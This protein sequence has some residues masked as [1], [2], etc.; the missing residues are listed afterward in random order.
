MTGVGAV[1]APAVVVRTVEAAEPE[2]VD[3]RRS[4]LRWGIGSY[5]VITAGIVL[6]GIIR[7]HGHL[8]YVIDDPAIHLSVAKNLVD[9]G[10]WG[11][12][13]GQFQSASSSPLW[14]IL[15]GAWLKIMPG[16]DALAPL[17]LN[18]AAAIGAIAVVAGNQRVLLPRWRRPLDALAVVVLVNVILFLPGLAMTGMEHSLHIALVLG[19][20]VLFHR[21]LTGQA[22]VGPSWLP[23]LL[24]VLATLTRFETAF[25]AAG[26]ALAL[27]VAPLARRGLDVAPG[28]D[29][30]VTRAR[31]PVLV[32]LASVVPLIAFGAFN[33]VMGQG[34]LPNSV[35]AK[36][37]TT[38]GV[39][40]SLFEGALSRFG[41]DA[42][43]AALA[44]VALVGLILAG[45]RWLPWSFPAIVVVVTIGLHM[46]F[47]RVGWYERY[48]AYLIALGV[49]AVLCLLAERLPAV[50]LPP[51]RSF[52]VAALVGVMLL[53]T[54]SKPGAV[55]KSPV[56]VGE[57]YDQR[58]QAARFFAEYY[59]G[60]PIA[61]GELGYIS[62]F[63]HGPITD[64]FGLGDYE[65]LQEWQR[66]DGLPKAP[67]WDRLAD[68]RG[69][70]VVAV[71]PLTLFRS[72]P[73]D[74]IAVGT[75]DLDRWITT[76]PSSQFQW[77]ATSPEAVEPL[78]QHLIDFEDQLPAG[79]KTNLNPLAENRA[80][81]LRAE[82]AAAGGTDAAGG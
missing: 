76:A 39:G 49:Y 81:T 70:Q 38:S 17:A 23:Y 56:A 59:D 36:A 21:R 58:Y 43:V 27:L 80:D 34:W 13:P 1:Q 12:V 37:A 79:V 3:F 6:G 47:A 8:V 50:E 78:R 15:L 64:V 31:E 51:A 16:P 66:A 60:Q 9:H 26:I 72:L 4:F 22:Q 67:Y 53:F 30:W 63:H 69:F 7:A 44:G 19:A 54:G 65:V 75:W 77:Y 48:Q 71:Y 10:T 82:A 74:W 45:R 2:A 20:V 33:E 57:T 61:T 32:G 18:V 55:F 11:V 41:T 14:T 68:E 73:D 24:V 42:L 29:G 40:G 35:M 25:V 52:V 5:L 28:R 62:L 46:L